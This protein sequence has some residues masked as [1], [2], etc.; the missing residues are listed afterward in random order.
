MPPFF[1]FGKRKN[2][3]IQE[4]VG[5]GARNEDLAGGMSALFRRALNDHPAPCSRRRKRPSRGMNNHKKFP[6]LRRE[7]GTSPRE[8]PPAASPAAEKPPKETA[9]ETS[10]G[11]DGDPAVR[12]GP[13]TLRLAPG[14][15]DVPLANRQPEVPVGFEASSLLLTEPGSIR[16]DERRRGRIRELQALHAHS[17]SSGSAT[18]GEFRT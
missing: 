14:R 10:S 5:N 6:L 11:R 8:R 2:K 4:T 15:E 17:R 12:P 7:G 13:A 16:A 1:P 3:G 18:R 9:E